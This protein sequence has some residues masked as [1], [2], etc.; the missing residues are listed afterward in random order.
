MRRGEWLKA[1]QQQ[2]KER[3]L[4]KEPVE[5]RAVTNKV[6]PWNGETKPCVHPGFV[7]KVLLEPTRAHLFSVCA[8]LAVGERR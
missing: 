4:A 2:G 5:S 3:E 6:W 7:K 1:G 8:V